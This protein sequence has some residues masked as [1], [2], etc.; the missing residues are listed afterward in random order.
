MNTP[1]THQAPAERTV[2]VSHPQIT[3]AMILCGIVSAAGIGAASAATPADDNVPSTVV[4]YNPQSLSTDSG[5]QAVYRTL[6]MA[7][8][9]V[10]PANFDRGVLSPAV[11]ECRAQSISRAVMQINDSKLAAIHDSA[12]RK[13]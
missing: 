9:E 7:A 2:R 3:L 12:S 1:A 13:G 10:C 11:R 4:K 8:A 5:A 6:V